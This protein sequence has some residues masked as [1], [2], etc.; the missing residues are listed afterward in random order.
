MANA[1][2]VDM[3]VPGAR[4]KS[5]V[6]TRPRLQS[7]PSTILRT[8][9]Q[10]ISAPARSPGAAPTFTT[11]T[12]SP[13]HCPFPKSWRLILIALL[14]AIS[15]S[16]CHAGAVVAWGDNSVL[17]TTVPPGISNAVNV[18]AGAL[19]SLAL[20]GDGTV[21]GWGYNFFG[22]ATPPPGLTNV[23]ALGAGSAHSLALQPTGA[24]IGWGV[25][26]P[27]PPDLT[28]AI[29]I[30]SGFD[31]NLA[32]R[33][34]RTVTAWGSQTNV[35]DGLTNIVAVAAGNGQNLALRLNGT[36]FAWGD[37]AFG[38]T[39]APAG[40]NFLAIAAG[41]DHCLALRRDGTVA[42][43]GNN[44]SG[45]TNVPAGLSNVVAI[46]AGGKHNLALKRDGTLAAWGDNTYNQSTITPGLAGFSA[47]AAGGQHSLAVRGDGSPFITL[48]PLSQSPVLTKS[49]RL[50]VLVVGAPPLNLQWQHNGTNLVNATNSFLQINN[51][52][53]TDAGDYT[54]IAANFAG[55]VTSVVATLSPIGAAPVVLLPPQDKSTFCGDSPSLQVTVDGSTPFS[56][57]WLFEGTPVAGA[58]RSSLAL[59]RINTNQAGA[60]SVAVTNSF[61]SITSVTAQ[62]TVLV[63][64]PLITSP[65]AAFGKQGQPFLYTITGK[66]APTTFEAVFLPAGL[67][68]NPTNGVI[69]GLPLENGSFGSLITARNACASDTETLVLSIASSVPTI[70]SP[71]TATG[72]EETFFSYQITATDSP[73]SFAA[74]GLPLGLS[75]SPATGL[76]SGISVYA[77]EFDAT[78]SA[79]NQWGVGS[80]PLHLSF[81]NVPITGLSIANVSYNYSSPYLLD[82]EFS[83][84]DN[85]D[86]SQGHAVVAT[87]RLLSLLCLEDGLSISPSETAFIVQRGSSKLMK[88][89]LVLDFTESVADLA[90]GDSNGDDI[91]DA[92]D[93]VVA[94]SQLLVNQEPADAQI[95]VYEF[96]REDVDPQKVIGLTTDKPAVNSAI[97][98]IWTNYVQ[99]FPAASRCWDAL[100][101]AINGLGATNRDEQHFIVFISDGRDESSL[102][103]IN[104]VVN[105][106]TTNNVKIYCIGFG[107]EIN[108]STLMFITAQTQGRFYSATN[109][110]D[111]VAQFAEVSK[112]LTSQYLLRWATLKRT[113]NSFM[114]SFQVG[115]QGFLAG[116][117]TNPVIVSTNIVPPATNPPP[118]VT[119]FIIAPY[120]PTQHTGSVTI[121]SLRFVANAEVLPRSVTLRASYVPR[122]IRQIRLHYRPNW[123]CV[124]T[125]QSTNQGEILFGWSLSQTND[126]AGGQWLSL[127]SPPPQSITNSIPFGTLGN[128]VHFSLRDMVDATNAFSLFDVDNTLYTNTG[129]QKFV[130]ENTNSFITTYP[131]LPFATPVPW[132][133]ANGFSGNFVLAETGDPDADGVPTWRE[134]QANTDPRDPNSKFFIRALAQ[135]LDGR[136]QLTFTT[137]HNRSYRVDASADLV[138]WEVVE[139]NIAGIDADVTVIDERFLP[140][141]SSLFYRVQV[142]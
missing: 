130:F 78:I 48:Q 101:A 59:T 26:F 55:S 52:Q 133:I 119:N 126:G 67:A 41:A 131:A 32:I 33:S 60:Y 6:T 42:A 49:V 72:T 118:P 38:K 125:L 89:Y 65:L 68:V 7:I 11:M 37:N 104:D 86:P 46:S 100:V 123:P 105:L 98:G 62:V 2:T 103:T 127:L 5:L 93:A 135:A 17:Q 14:A 27:P 137:S 19:H 39:N 142:Y 56:Y 22:Q 75:L 95:G 87:P 92:V 139:D 110:V 94:G 74:D 63:E 47:I 35:P 96:H 64:P 138:N 122:F 20:S 50:Q 16:L 4:P 40:S 23:V 120:V 83:L 128:L 12:P 8:N 51:V 29:A 25:P 132:L 18:A 58:T 141:T 82:F 85:D 140:G 31:Y 73:T 79:S 1:K 114:P 90:N 53:V 36:L 30:A 34:D 134:Y 81:D 54:A 99:Y 66:H 15:P 21:T 61:G 117:P 121:G 3:V 84:R 80:A 124:A 76:I 45:Q 44:S 70:T 112:D 91:S 102:S 106:A 57:Q 136:Y 113:T 77:G 129:G 10:L 88:S 71:A 43:W 108:F 109:A 115:Y 69:S 116:S 28:N 13:S 111:L 24:L 97:A 9:D 107:A